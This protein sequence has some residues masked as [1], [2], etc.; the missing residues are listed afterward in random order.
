[1]ERDQVED[2]DEDT[3]GRQ[4]AKQVACAPSDIFGRVR[5]SV[6]HI[7]SDRHDP[8]GVEH[9]TEDEAVYGKLEHDGIL[10]FGSSSRPPN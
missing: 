9:E 10:R 7:A 3:D 8:H 6:G 2:E 5:L 4:Q 1:V